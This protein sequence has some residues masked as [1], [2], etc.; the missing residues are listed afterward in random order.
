MEIT[1]IDAK[2]LPEAWFLCIKRCVEKGYPY[3]IDRGSFA[4]QRRL[5]LDFVVVKIEYPGSK[6]LIPDTPQ[7]VPP[8]RLWITLR[9]ISPT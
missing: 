9:G 2:T 7:G 1:H 5:E 6:P 4:G 8:Q 3:R